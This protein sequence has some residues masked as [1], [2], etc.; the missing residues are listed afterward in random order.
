MSGQT[1]AAI[2]ALT[3]F[4]VGCIYQAGRLAARLER[5]EEW[6]IEMRSDMLQIQATLRRIELAMGGHTE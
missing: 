1:L 4:V 2:T 5:L 3:L 6:R